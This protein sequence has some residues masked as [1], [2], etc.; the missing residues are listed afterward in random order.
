MRQ[1]P[2]AGDCA[3]GSQMLGRDWSAWQGSG[4]ASELVWWDWSSGWWQK[5]FWFDFF[6]A[7]SHLCFLRSTFKFW[8]L[9][10]FFIECHFFVRRFLFVGQFKNTRGLM[11][12]S[13][14]KQ[15]N[16]TVN[17]CAL[18]MC[19]MFCALVMKTKLHINSFCYLQ[20]VWRLSVGLIICNICMFS[21]SHGMLLMTH[22][23]TAWSKCIW[24]FHVPL[25]Y[26]IIVLW[27]QLNYIIK[28]GSPFASVHI[29]PESCDRIHLPSFALWMFGRLPHILGH[30]KHT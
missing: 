15:T 17:Q 4:T 13:F 28:A 2:R 29:P 1:R 9:D 21:T 26:S 8:K 27:F 7:R 22:S 10:H 3:D 24:T 20:P 6:C 30:Q 19:N 5:A 23:E 25:Q 12:Q 11:S 16:Q 14:E 18:W